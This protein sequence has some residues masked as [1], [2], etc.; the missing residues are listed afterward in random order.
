[1]FALN[2]LGYPSRRATIDRRQFLGAAAAAAAA[3]PSSRL[4]ADI[5]A[6]SAALPASL[7]AV[8]ASGKPV[9]LSAYG[10]R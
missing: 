3:F 10:Y 9:T 7:V 1:M 8:G 6:P 4:W 5:S 2:P